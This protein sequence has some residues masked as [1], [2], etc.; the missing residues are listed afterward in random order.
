MVVDDDDETLLNNRDNLFF[1]NLFQI[2]VNSCPK[3]KYV[4]PINI[5]QLEVIEVGWAN[6]LEEVFGRHTDRADL[7]NDKEILLPQL[8]QLSLFYLPN[9]TNFCSVGYHFIFP[10]LKSLLVRNCPKPTHKMINPC[11]PKQRYLQLFTPSNLCIALC[12]YS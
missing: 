5:Q 4:F 10:S 3:L 11:M 12:C 2:K 7:I 8:Q 6:Q 9:L 1:P